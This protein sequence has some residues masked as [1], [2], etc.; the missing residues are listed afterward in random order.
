VSSLVLI[1]SE[2]TSSELNTSL[3]TF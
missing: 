3:L 2:L 1:F